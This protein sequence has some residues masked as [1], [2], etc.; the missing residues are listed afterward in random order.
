ML[1]G[2]RGAERYRLFALRYLAF[3]IYVDQFVVDG[4]WHCASNSAVCWLWTTEVLP[5]V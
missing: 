3:R 5:E 1:E 4:V 2:S